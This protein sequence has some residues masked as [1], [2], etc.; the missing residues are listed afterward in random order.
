ME[1]R[2]P[3]VATVRTIRNIYMAAFTSDCDV[4]LGMTSDVRCFVPDASM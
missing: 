4:N 2:L 3:L 1:T